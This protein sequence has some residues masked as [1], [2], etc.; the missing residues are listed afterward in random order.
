MRYPRVI[1]QTWHTSWLYRQPD[2]KSQLTPHQNFLLYASDTWTSVRSC[3]CWVS[4]SITG[5]A[6]QRARRSLAEIT[7]PPC[8]ICNALTSATTRPWRSACQQTLLPVRRRWPPWILLRQAGSAG[9]V[10]TILARARGQDYDRYHYWMRFWTGACDDFA[11]WV[12]LED[13]SGGVMQ[14]Y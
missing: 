2:S 9:A 4:D 1:G 10:L 13:T 11:R 7:L 8:P 3:L 14:R 5:G 12:P 6:P